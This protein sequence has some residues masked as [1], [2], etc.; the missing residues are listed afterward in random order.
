MGTRLGRVKRRYAAASVLVS[1]CAFATVLLAGAF[2]HAKKP[3]PPA[4]PGYAHTLQGILDAARPAGE[5]RIIVKGCVTGAT[6]NRHFCTWIANGECHAGM[7]LDTP[8]EGTVPES[9]GKALV[10]PSK[11]YPVNVLH[12]L[13]S[14]VEEGS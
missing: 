1:G 11:C 3:V 10:P 4:Q 2:T 8:G 5:A 9:H 13:G 7:I 12:W 6:L 14:Q